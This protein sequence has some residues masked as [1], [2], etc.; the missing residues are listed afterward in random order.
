MTDQQVSPRQ[1]PDVRERA[2]RLS[3]WIRNPCRVT[4][5]GGRW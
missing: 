4:N 2:R 3:N 1:V 5:Q